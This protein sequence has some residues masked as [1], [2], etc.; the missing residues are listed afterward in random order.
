[1]RQRQPAFQGNLGD[2]TL[3]FLFAKEKPYTPEV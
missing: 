3:P 1:M 2:F